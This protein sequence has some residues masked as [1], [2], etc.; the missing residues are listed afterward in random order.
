MVP[1]GLTT[2]KWYQWADSN[3]SVFTDLQAF[4]T[5]LYTYLYTN[6][7]LIP[8]QKRIEGA[9]IIQPPAPFGHSLIVIVPT[10]VLSI[11]FQKK[12]EKKLG[13]ELGR[14][15]KYLSEENY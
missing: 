12:S 8:P 1:N 14:Y 7:T 6:R 15:M 13:L 10:P 11:G 3:T 2:Y 5:N 4:Y 9:V